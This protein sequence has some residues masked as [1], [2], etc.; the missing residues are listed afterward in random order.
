MGRS[1]HISVLIGVL[2][3]FLAA[4]FEA[5]VAAPAMNFNAQGASVENV[6]GLPLIP[7][8]QEKQCLPV[9]LCRRGRRGRRFCNLRERCRE[10]RYVKRCRRG[11]GC[12]WRDV[13]TW[14]QPRR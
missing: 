10:C 6:L 9:S 11:R 3:I 2:I 1:T 8:V 7:V 13:C 12:V 14:R 5:V 4:A